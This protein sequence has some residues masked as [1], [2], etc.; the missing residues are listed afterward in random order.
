[1][2]ISR[3]DR[4][5]DPVGV[6]RAHRIVKRY[7]DCQLV[8]AGGTADDDPEGAA[9][10]AETR[11]A[12]AADPDIHLLELPPESPLEVNALQTAATIVIQKSLRERFGLTRISHR[13]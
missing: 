4:L 12:A 1:V 13:I 2:Q 5:K 10:L 3:F 8:L 9:V 7:F 11:D 6:V